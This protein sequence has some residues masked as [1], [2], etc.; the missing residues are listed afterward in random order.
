MKSLKEFVLLTIIFPIADKLM[1]TCAMKWHKQIKEMNSWTK[2]EVLNWQVSR[3]KLLIEHAYSNTVYYKELFDS[4]DLKPSDINSFEDLS[5]IPPLTKDIIRNRYEDIIPKNIKSFKH[6]IGHTGGSTGTPLKYFFDEDN[7][8]YVT[9]MKIASW[10]TTGYQYGDLFVSL[11]S[12]SL[13]SVNKKNP[14]HEIYFRLKNTIPL[15]GM[16][17]DDAVCK[18]YTDIII[19]Y[20]VKYIY[21]YATAIFL[22]ALYC[23]KNNIKLPIQWAYTTAEKLTEEYRETIEKTWNA[24]VM[25]CYGSRDGGLTA[26]EVE[27]GFYDVGYISY[28]ETENN[29]FNPSSLMLTNLCSFS[30]PMIRYV[31]GDEVL[32]A[33]EGRDNYNGQVIKQVIGRTSDVLQLSNGKKLTTS[34]FNSMFRTFNIHAFRIR[35]SGELELTIQIQKKDNFL[36]EE[37]ELIIDTMHKYAGNDCNIIIDYVEKFEPLKNGKRSF[38]MN[39]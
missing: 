5:K 4:L 20:N 1:G 16:N 32:L 25:D 38:F 27:R 7:W 21:G 10:Q 19:K 15:N 26:Y 24:K 3:L 37:E 14:I 17:M 35:K 22:L 6:R 31:N 23:K 18:R 13:F 12:S 11:G 34:G 2:D 8:G 33:P 36:I 29:T 30:Y 28:C 39:E 9:A